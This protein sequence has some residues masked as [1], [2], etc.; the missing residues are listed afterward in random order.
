MLAMN[1]KTNGGAPCFVEIEDKLDT[2]YSLIGC[3]LIDIVSKRI[4][5][6]NFEIVCDDEGLLKDAPIITAVTADGAPALVGGLVVLRYGGDGEL[7]GLNQEDV[8][9]LT[10]AVQYSIQQNKLQAVLVL[11]E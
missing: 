5:G 2:Y 3:D 9:R 1:I 11:D 10:N 7:A 8:L 4:N 6:A